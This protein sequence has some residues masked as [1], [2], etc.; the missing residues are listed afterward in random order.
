LKKLLLAAA[1]VALLATS[2]IAPVTPLEHYPAEYVSMGIAPEMTQDEQIDFIFNVLYLEEQGLDRDLVTPPTIEVG[3][4]P[5]F[6][7]AGAISGWYEGTDTIYVSQW[8]VDLF[9]Y[10]S[11]EVQKTIIHE[12]VHYI[13]STYRG[14]TERGY[15]GPAWKWTEENAW[16]VANTY[17]V[18]SGYPDSADYEWW[19]RYGF[20]NARPVTPYDPR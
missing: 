18:W 6:W 4:Y 13:D 14:N 15:R 7:Y 2:A 19:E 3:W 1:A 17:W 11:L 5:N 8:L 12:T 16:H 10:D 20:N 9:G